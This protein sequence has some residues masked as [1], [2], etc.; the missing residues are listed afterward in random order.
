LT[1][2]R[3]GEVRADHP[4]H[5]GDAGG[6]AG[7]RRA[8]RP[9]EAIEDEPLEHGDEIGCCDSGLG[10]TEGFEITGRV[11]LGEQGRGQ[12]CVQVDVAEQTDDQCVASDQVGPV[13]PRG[14]SR[15]P[16]GHRTLLADVR[17]PGC[18]AADFA[19]VCGSPLSA[20]DYLGLAR[21][22]RRW[23]VGNVPELRTVPM[24]WSTRLVNLVD[25]LY[26]A[27]L[28][29]TI[30]AAAPLPDL[31]RNVPHVPDLS[32]AASRLSQLAQVISA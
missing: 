7:R 12:A 4:R 2:A 20:S 10:R 5:F 27:D 13:G 22:Y 1:A 31:V 21:A 24:D 14:T 3:G 23:D 16:V 18:L 28:E 15:I 8:A 32:R 26:D 25:I 9:G 17:E 6:F 29:L 19:E 30:H 11:C